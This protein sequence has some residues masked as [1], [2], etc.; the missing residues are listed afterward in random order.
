MNIKGLRSQIDQIDLQILELLNQ[1][2]DNAI[3][4]G[5]LKN[6][7]NTK[8]YAPHREKKIIERLHNQN[9]GPFP[10]SAL[11]SVYR[12]IISTCRAIEQPLEVAYLGPPGSFGHAASLKQFGSSTNFVPIQN[13][14]D[15]FIEVESG[16]A[17][18]GVVAIENSTAGIVRETV[19][20][21]I[22]S[23]LQICAEIMMPISHNLLSNSPSEKITKIYSHRQPFT[24]CR[25]WLRNN[26]QDVHQAVVS[27][28][29]EAAQRAA[30]EKGTAAIASKL[31]AEIYGLEVLYEFI[32]DNPGNATRFLVI[33]K[34]SGGKSVDDKTSV[35]FSVKDEPGALVKVLERFVKYGLNLSNIH[36]RPSQTKA[37][38]YVFFVDIDGHIED[39]AVKAALDDVE[40]V[41]VSVEILG[42]YPKAERDAA[43]AY[44]ERFGR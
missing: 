42:A 12:E 7:A 6:K 8:I 16:R 44:G 32:I 28:T 39:E 29:S 35:L 19:D 24:Q 37:W 10:N 34:H 2:I 5:D 15:I 36:S 20:M 40:Q 30:Q 31:A 13:Q 17:D 18:Y 43:T 38:E 14:P 33:G 23:N 11:T 1:R 22:Q 25:E 26:F 3:K 9:N 27:S 4:I 21:F 41:C